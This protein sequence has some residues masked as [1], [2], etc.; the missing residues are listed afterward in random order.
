MGHSFESWQTKVTRDH[1]VS[2]LE[3]HPVPGPQIL[4][5]SP[6]I[7]SLFI[8]HT[9]SMLRC[10]TKVITAPRPNADNRSYTMV[11]EFVRIP[12]AVISGDFQ[13]KGVW[14][15]GV[16]GGIHGAEFPYREQTPIGG[17]KRLGNDAA[18]LLDDLR[19]H[20]E[21]AHERD[22]SRR[23]PARGMHRIALWP[24]VAEGK[25]RAPAGLVDQRLVLDGIEDGFQRVLN[26]QHEAS[27][28]LLQFPSRIHQ[29]RRIRQE[30]QTRHHALESPGRLALGWRMCARADGRGSELT[31]P[32][33][34]LRLRDVGGHPPEQMTRSLDDMPRVVLAQIAA[35]QHH[36]GVRRKP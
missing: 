17:H 34:A 3:D 21:H 20:V 1:E 22:G 25:A 2:F 35:A 27:G 12:G 9:N 4:H 6:G 31:T 24:Q 5:M 16:W 23:N 19:G 30:F 33:Q 26:G 14:V 13:A 10:R 29:R 7:L 11:V 15:P 8:D 32:V 36:E 18:A 28:Q